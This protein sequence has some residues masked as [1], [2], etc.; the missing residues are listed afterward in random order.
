MEGVVT[1][2]VPLADDI[3]LGEGIV[4]IHY[5]E[6][7]ED[8][9]THT[10]GGIEYVEEIVYIDPVVGGVY[11]STRGHKRTGT[12][13]PRFMINVG[14]LTYDNLFKGIPH[15]QTDSGAYYSTRLNLNIE[16]TDIIDN[17]TFVGKT[18]GGLDTIVQIENLLNDG[19]IEMEFKEKAEVICKMQY[20]GF[21]TD[22]ITIPSTIIKN[23]E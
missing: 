12:R 4:Y 8:E 5:G 7:D 2:L 22:G 17:L 14:K 13:I 9:F 6:V 11:G 10:V 3:T 1:P 16:T 18:H 21:S 23:D 19:N 20:S 15:T